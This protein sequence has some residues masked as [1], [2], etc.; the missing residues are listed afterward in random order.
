MAR[1]NQAALA[2]RDVRG[3]EV[4]IRRPRDLRG[5]NARECLLGPV[6][7][8]TRGM[9]TD[10]HNRAYVPHVMS[11][12]AQ[13]VRL[14]CSGPSIGQL[15]ERHSTRPSVLHFVSRSEYSGDP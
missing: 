11:Q 5:G 7:L 2:S 15:R 4:G 6:D 12:R 13:T 10:A 9:A 1:Q 8:R 3:N 14:V